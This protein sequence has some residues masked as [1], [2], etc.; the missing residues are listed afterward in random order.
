MPEQS[1]VEFDRTRKNG[2]VA[3]SRTKNTRKR[4]REQRKE[5]QRENAR[6]ARQTRKM[7]REP[8]GK[9]SSLF[10]NLAHQKKYRAHGTTTKLTR[11]RKPERS[12]GTRRS[13]GCRR[14]G[15][16]PC[17][18]AVGQ[19]ESNTSS[20]SFGFA[21]L[22]TFFTLRFSYS[23]HTISAPSSSSS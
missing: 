3:L 14:S 21:Q 17:S 18:A 15:A 4:G 9:P 8:F 6:A 7:T 11:R 22:L 10:G 13:V 20:S 12:R 19:S 2:K 16:A 5:G 23:F 1:T